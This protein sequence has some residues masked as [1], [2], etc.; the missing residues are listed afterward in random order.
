MLLVLVDCVAIAA[1]GTVLE[2]DVRSPDSTRCL[3]VWVLQVLA[4]VPR[5]RCTRLFVLLFDSERPAPHS[6]G[7]DS[8]LKAALSFALLTG[9]LD[10]AHGARVVLLRYCLVGF[11][12]ELCHAAGRR[13]FHFTGLV[14]ELD[15]YILLLSFK[16]DF[17]G[18]EHVV[19]PKHGL[20][21]FPLLRL[22]EHLVD[23]RGLAP[24]WPH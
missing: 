1:K 13:S 11:S 4:I 8:S 19:F 12:S 9:N 22:T 14:R 23:E 15:K 7:D 3:E 6:D 2:L 17:H 18:F 16:S 24:A 10:F 21:L 5:R 20:L